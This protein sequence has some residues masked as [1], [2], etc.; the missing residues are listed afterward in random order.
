MAPDILM[1]GLE[2]A[3]QTGRLRQVYV[4]NFADELIVMLL[5]CVNRKLCLFEKCLGALVTCVLLDIFVNQIAASQTRLLV[6]NILTIPLFFFLFCKVF[7]RCFISTQFQQNHFLRRITVVVI[8]L[9]L[10][11]FIVSASQMSQDVFSQV[12]HP[13]A[14]LCTDVTHTKNTSNTLAHI[15]NKQTK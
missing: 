13:V 4:A 1:N 15:C 9:L 5:F 3:T 10:R 11:C 12:C 6:A 14:H 8:E 2:M 7:F